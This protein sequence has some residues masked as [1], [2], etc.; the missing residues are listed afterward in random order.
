MNIKTGTRLICDELTRRTGYTAITLGKGRIE[1]TSPRRL[2]LRVLTPP[3]QPGRPIER[4][5]ENLLR[6]AG[7]LGWHPTRR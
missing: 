1:L 4:A 5:A 2:K 6:R 7:E 3:S